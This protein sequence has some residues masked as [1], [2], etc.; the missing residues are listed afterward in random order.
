MKAYKIRIIVTTLLGALTCA[1]IGAAPAP[2]MH[3]NCVPLNENDRRYV[4]EH[5][6]SDFRSSIDVIKS[7]F[8]M[9]KA[10]FL[11]GPF[12]DGRGGTEMRFLKAWWLWKP[13][14]FA[15]LDPRILKLLSHIFDVDYFSLLA[16]LL[17]DYYH[18]RGGVHAFANDIEAATGSRGDIVCLVSP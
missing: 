6:A 14:D 7:R 1:S 8:V 13:D 16:E 10:P 4:R 11:D 17:P 18:T 12:P 2:T 15:K 3:P 5:T 9:T